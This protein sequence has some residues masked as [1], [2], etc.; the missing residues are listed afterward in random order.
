MDSQQTDPYAI[1]IQSLWE[2]YEKVAMHFNDLLMRLRSQGLAGIAAIATIV[3]IITKSGTSNVDSNW[4]L[5]TAIFI[6]LGVFWIAIFFLDFFYYNRLLA[7]AVTAITKLEDAQCSKTF[8]GIDLSKTIVAEFNKLPSLKSYMGVI[9]FYLLVL[10]VIFTGACFSYGMSQ[11]TPSDACLHTGR[12][13][14]QSIS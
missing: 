13:L 1:N 3:G 4:L 2:K 8:S 11:K 7:G 9:I 12:A 6:A 10:I 14:F 5:A